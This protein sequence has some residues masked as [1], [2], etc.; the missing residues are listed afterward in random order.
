MQLLISNP[1]L[2][3]K[4]KEQIKSWGKDQ[5]FIIADFDRTLTYGTIDGKKTPSII[6]LLRDGKHLTEDY[7]EQAHA[8]YD[9]Y[10][11]FEITPELPLEIKKEKMEERWA[12]HNQLL[13]Q[14]GLR[15]QDLQDIAKNRHL[16]L[17]KG[18]QETLEYLEN[19]HIPFIIFSASGCG[20]A[21]P[22]FMEHH[23]CNYSNISYVINRFQRDQ[24]GFGKGVDWPIIHSFNKDEGVFSKLPLLQEKL[25][26]RKNVI[27]IGDSLGDAE[28][29]SQKDHTTIL[30]IWIL[31]EATLELQS[32]Y[33]DTF[34]L[35]LIGDWDFYKILALINELF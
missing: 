2:F 14:S 6:S 13:M 3:Q 28:M 26:A 20:D 22:I 7:A 16:H 5:C 15:L 30:K 17:R 12:K 29:A 34:D 32:A 8:L 35:V 18:V 24:K 11:S 10:H 31:T 33:E 9:H 4:K 19:K 23:K 1:L 27:L 21:I 25:K